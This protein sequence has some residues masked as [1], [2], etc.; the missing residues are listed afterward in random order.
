MRGS[1][2][3]AND[4]FI[5]NAVIDNSNRATHTVS[6]GLQCTVYCSKA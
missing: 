6:D 2:E 4:G 5:R 3:G 1:K